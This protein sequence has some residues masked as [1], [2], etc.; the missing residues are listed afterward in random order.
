M[1]YTTIDDP[2]IYFNTLLYTGNGSNPRTLTGVGFQP[3]WVWLK[4]RTDANGHTLADAVRGANIT[5]SSDG[6]GAE[7]TDKSDGHLDAF[8]S[9]GFT[10]GAGTD[11]ARVNNTSS[12]YVAWNWKAGTTSGISGSP[13]ITPS[14]YS[15]N[16]TAGFSIIAY[17]GNASVGAT[18]PHGLGV[19]P[20]VIIF[21][22]RDSNVKWVVY[23]HKNT[24][25]PETDH[26]QLD[27]DSATSDDDSILNDTAPGSS[28]ITM[29]TSSS[30]NSNG[31]KYVAYCF[32]EIKGYSKFGS[33][34]GNSSTDGPFLYMG[35]KPAFLMV[36]RTNTTENWYMKDNKRDP[37]ND[38]NQSAL[39][40]NGS[41]VEDTGGAW[42]T[43]DA[44]ANGFK[45]RKNDTSS[46]GSG[47]TYVYF[48]FAE[49]PF[50]NSN[51]VPTNAR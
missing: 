37:F 29:K 30:V 39:Y 46:N 15:F 27:N 11:D 21:K 5:L 7:V 3:D 13:S 38:M 17:T 36:K 34:Q 26:L 9:D 24:S 2:T 25:A 16:Q 48:A 4:N 8:T 28:L 10:V 1:A 43:G 49:S 12:N 40:A 41:A 6:S 22:N 14:G 20:A 18:I 33:Y 44:C 47:S 19:A 35:F 31:V 23:H 51:G 50:V 32:S 45:I 42:L